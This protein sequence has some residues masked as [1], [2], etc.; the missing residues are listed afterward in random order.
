MK[1]FANF[2]VAASLA[3]V[4]AALSPDITTVSIPLPSG[5]EPTQPPQTGCPTV[6]KTR[7][8]C[9]TCPVPAC[10][11][12]STVTQSCGCPSVIPTV[13]LDFPCSDGCKNIWC[14]TYFATASGPACSTTTDLPQ[15]TITFTNSTITLSKTNT[16]PPPDTTSC[17]E[18]E[19]EETSTAPPPD[20]TSCGEEDEPETKTTTKI[21]TVTRSASITT[22]SLFS[23]GTASRTT[24]APTSSRTFVISN[25]AG[26]MR[27]FG[28][29]G[30]WW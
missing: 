27:V 6:T 16:T 3:A 22:T 2:P 21:H 4:V 7:E 12:L 9:A 19:P 15:P 14:E 29:W 23:N 26:R 11:V 28:G 13:Y 5:F 20:T 1:S 8:L 25:N 30:L 10:A 18:D 24:T 17:E